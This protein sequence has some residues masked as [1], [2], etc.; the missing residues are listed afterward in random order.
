MGFDVSSLLDRI[1]GTKAGEDA[2]EELQ[3]AADAE[4]LTARRR[5]AEE[6]A[7]L[8]AERATPTPAAD[9]AERTAQALFNTLSAQLADAAAKLRIARGN[10]INRDARLDR[11]IGR[12]ECELRKT[13]P[14]MIDAFVQEM[15]AAHNATR[16]MQADSSEVFSGKRDANGNKVMEAWSSLPAIRRRL[17]AINK[18]RR[19]AEDL[20]LEALDALELEAELATL[21]NSIPEAKKLERVA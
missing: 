9:E 3:A 6:L 18:A 16:E 12:L 1:A 5:L 13:A 10:R 14:P 2:L 21:R 11:K 7:A 4:R 8:K 19:A 20:K 17:D 15:N